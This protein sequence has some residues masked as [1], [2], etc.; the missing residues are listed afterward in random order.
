MSTAGDSFE[1]Q[2]EEYEAQADVVRDVLR[3]PDR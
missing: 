3:T 1:R 2:L